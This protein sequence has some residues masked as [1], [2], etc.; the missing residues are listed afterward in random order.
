MEEHGSPSET[1]F[2]SL[3][4]AKVGRDALST[5]SRRSKDLGA[6]TSGDGSLVRRVLRM[7]WGKDTKE[8][9]NRTTTS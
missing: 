1:R 8:V 6:F 3:Q 5:P 7:P 2:R 4:G 9:T